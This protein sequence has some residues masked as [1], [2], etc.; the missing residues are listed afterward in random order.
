VADV[1]EEK[2]LVDGDVGDVLI[3]GGVSG[4]LVGVLFP[5][6]VCFTTLLVVSFLLHLPF[7]FLVV[8][9]ITVT[10]I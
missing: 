7:P 8:V 2:S 3:G 5:P 1:W 10:Y 9:P 6:H 4:A